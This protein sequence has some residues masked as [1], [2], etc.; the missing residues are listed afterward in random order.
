MDKR[1]NVCW[2]KHGSQVLST[3]PDQSQPSTPTQ[4]GNSLPKTSP[5]PEQKKLPNSIPTNSTS[6]E[7]ED[8]LI[9]CPHDSRISYENL[10]HQCSRYG[11]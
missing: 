2:L 10:G 7:N 8:Q 11:L 5:L 6:D 3:Q 4:F 1:E 9:P